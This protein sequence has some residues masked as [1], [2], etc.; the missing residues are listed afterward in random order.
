M[1]EDFTKIYNLINFEPKNQNKKFAHDLFISNALPKEM[2]TDPE[3]IFL[4]GIYM[5]ENNCI[6][7]ALDCY[8]KILETEK[9]CLNRYAM[10]LHAKGQTNEAIKYYELSIQNG[11][12][13]AINNLAGCYIQVKNYKKAEELC[14]L[15]T[16]KGNKSAW[17]NL[18]YLFQTQNK[19]NE[20]I[21]CY[22]KAIELGIEVAIDNLG[23]LY[24]TQKDINKAMEYF[25][26]S[27]EKYK[28]PKS[29]L[30]IGIC[31]RDKHDYPNAQKYFEMS[32]GE[33]NNQLAA[34]ELRDLLKKIR[35]EKREAD[36]QKTSTSFARK[37]RKKKK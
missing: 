2:P 11:N 16:E 15:A 34:D 12:N 26:L 36:L 27:I 25:T 18:G 31:Y 7:L 30:H 19:A 6:D 22:K 20:A 4:M 23:Q 5:Q 3:Q 33:D 14:R 8:S 1:A 21:E 37:H 10:I 13:S 17:N 35:L 32:F 28:S 29:M 24:Y 9:R